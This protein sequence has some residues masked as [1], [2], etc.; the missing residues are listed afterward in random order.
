MSV[1]LHESIIDDDKIDENFID[2]FFCLFDVENNKQKNLKHITLTHTH[3]CAI[4]LCIKLSSH[5]IQ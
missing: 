1:L 3:K 4:C 2:W 5:L